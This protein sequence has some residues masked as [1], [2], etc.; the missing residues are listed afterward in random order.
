MNSERQRLVDVATQHYIALHDAGNCDPL[1]GSPVP[2]R[3][4]R[5]PAV[6][7][8]RNTML[9]ATIRTVVGE[10]YCVEI[11]SPRTLGPIFRELCHTR[12]PAEPVVR[13]RLSYEGLL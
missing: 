7:I 9:R 12:R 13:V 11:P 1:V 6:I 4:Q 3:T 5:V 2:F 8:P 10:V